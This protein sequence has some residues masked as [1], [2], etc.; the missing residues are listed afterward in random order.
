MSELAPVS[1]EQ[2]AQKMLGKSLTVNL[3]FGTS[4]TN[5][6]IYL[7]VAHQALERE[8]VENCSTIYECGVCR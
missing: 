6:A 1:A 5:T 7:C 3:D 8:K 4:T 2:F